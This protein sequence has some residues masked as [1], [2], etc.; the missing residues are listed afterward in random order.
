MPISS[1]DKIEL[2]KRKLW[3]KAVKRRDQLK[4]EGL[5]PKD[6]GNQAVMEFLGD[7]AHPDKSASLSMPVQK[8][9]VFE[10]VDEEPEKGL[11][12][13]AEIEKGI[14]EL[15]KKSR[16]L[17]MLSWVA[18]NLR[19]S[20]DM[21]DCPGRD[22]WSLLYDCLHFP[23]LRMDFWKTMWTKGVPNRAQ[24]SDGDENFELDGQMTLDVLTKISN[25]V[26]KVK[27]TEEEPEESEWVSEELD[28]VSEELD[29]V[30]ECGAL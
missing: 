13:F 2:K 7:D 15:P 24:L 26:N 6:A 23:S 20:I 11:D 18:G 28:E 14:D 9:E 3:D 27:N 17:D 16:H 25:I 4:E 19:G 5:S 1:V 30:P 8:K 21:E 10:E 29:E 12:I 22:A